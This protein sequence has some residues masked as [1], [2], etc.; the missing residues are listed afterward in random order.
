MYNMKLYKTGLIL[1]IGLVAAMTAG[2][3]SKVLKE[4]WNGSGR[5]LSNNDWSLTPAT[6]SNI[7]T[8]EI[9]SNTGDSYATRLTA[10]VT[11]PT[12]GTYV[13]YVGPRS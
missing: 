11:I 1:F 4:T 7:D 5:L 8:F 6:T 2:E 3:A 12:T 13:F 9:L 10:E